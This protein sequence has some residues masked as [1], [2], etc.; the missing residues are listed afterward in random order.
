MR[1]VNLGIICR[2]SRRYLSRQAA[3]VVPI[4]R[5]S[6]AAFHDFPSDAAQVVNLKDTPDLSKE[7]LEQAEVS[8]CDP[9]NAGNASLSEKSV[10]S[11]LK[12]HRSQ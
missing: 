5:H 6:R 10:C 7:A 1:P 2:E 3:Y 12:P 11:S 9:N 4:T 8:A